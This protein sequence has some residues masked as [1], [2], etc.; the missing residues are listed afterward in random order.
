MNATK[1]ILTQNCL[2][3]GILC[4]VYRNPRVIQI[5]QL[6][7]YQV[8]KSGGDICYFLV[9]L[10]G[11]LFL[12]WDGFLKPPV[13][14][15]L[16]FIQSF[17]PLKHLMLNSEPYFLNWE[18]ML[19]SIYFQLM[20]APCKA[21]ISVAVARVDGCSS[22]STS[23]GYSGSSSSDSDSGNSSDGE[24]EGASSIFAMALLKIVI[25]VL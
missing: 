15:N 12:E 9:E 8:F 23:N 21:I 20:H 6:L 16:M 19:W 7:F 25:V 14:S 17:W 3:M 13:W 18:M 10:L 22:P 2:L 11:Q 4:H 24:S 1:G 5:L